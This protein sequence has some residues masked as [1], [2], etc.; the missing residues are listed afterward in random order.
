MLSLVVLV[1]ADIGPM[2]RFSANRAEVIEAILLEGARWRAFALIELLARRGLSGLPIF[3]T[4]A[5]KRRLGSPFLF[6]TFGSAFGANLGPATAQRGPRA[7]DSADWCPRAL[8]LRGK[9]F[10]GMVVQGL[11]GHRL[12]P[13]GF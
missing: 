4:R 8:Y 5:A 11:V 9:T 13:F 3:V 1:S 7:L 10:L 12:Q 2:A 6:A